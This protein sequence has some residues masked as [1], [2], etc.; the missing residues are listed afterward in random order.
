MTATGAQST[1]TIAN[2]LVNLCRQGRNDDA[3]ERLDMLS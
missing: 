2:E 3:I 1:S